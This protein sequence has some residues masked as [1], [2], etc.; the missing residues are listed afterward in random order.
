MKD[1]T[2]YKGKIQIDTDKA[3][4]IGNP[5]FDPTSYLLKSED[6][7]KIIYEQYHPNPPA[8]RKRGL[9]FETRLDGQ[10]VSSQ[11][12][13]ISPAPGIY[14]GAGFRVHP[15]FEIDGGIEWNPALSATNGFAVSD[16]TTPAANTRQ[17]QDF[18]MYT[19]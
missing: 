4:L 17:Y 18:F 15:A 5:P 12:L 10:V 2:V 13:P 16:S 14:A 11:A 9:L 1:G 3:V 6:I 8:E 7:A 19:G